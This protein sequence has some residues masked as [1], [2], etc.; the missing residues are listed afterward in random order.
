[1]SYK[2][3]KEEHIHTLDDI[4][5][6]GVT[7]VLSVIA[8]PALIQW[9]ANEA[10][11]YIKENS[12]GFQSIDGQST[13]FYSGIDDGLLDKARYAH[14]SK[15]DKAGDWGTTIHKAVEDWIKEGK[16][17][18]LEESQQKAFT[19]F[20]NWVEENKI[21]FLE[22]EKHVWSK[23]LWIGGITDMVIKMDGKKYVADIKTSSGIYDEMFFQMAAYALCLEEM[24]EHKDIE[25]YLVV[26]LK[27]DGNID[28]KR[29]DN[30][31]INKEAFLAALTLHKIKNSLK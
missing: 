18:S 7:T 22:S 27:K 11:K 16:E 13:P 21:E 24:G 23:E 26:N 17:P 12:S 30:M 19:N 6:H 2:F 8:K 4:P 14:R 1:M 9:S 15:K 10:I 20:K 5:L 25:G 29:A 28:F 31:A 3:N